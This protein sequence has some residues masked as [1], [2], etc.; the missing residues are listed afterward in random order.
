MICESVLG[1][2]KEEKYQSSQVDYVDFD[3]HEAYKKLHSKVSRGGKALGIRLDDHVLTH[4]LREGDVLGVSEDGQTV[5][6]VHILPCE[7]IVATVAADHPHMV[8][9]VAYE[10]GNT[11]GALFYGP[12]E[13]QYLT[14]YTEPMLLLLKKLH[15]VEVHVET[16]TFDF[17]RGVSSVVHNHHH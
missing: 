14:P 10:V 1:N 3:W 6:A 9:K 13:N 7:A 12:Q 2:I 8:A 11:H 15:G 5:C 16:V 17:D 4:G